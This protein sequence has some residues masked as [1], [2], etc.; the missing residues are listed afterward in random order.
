MKLSKNY[1]NIMKKIY[2]REFH[3][4]RTI[5]KYTFS[6][7]RKY[8][9][10]NKLKI[11]KKI[12]DL[13]VTNFR[14]S[15]DLNILEK[16]AFDDK[17]RFKS[18][19]RKSFLAKKENLKKS[20]ILNYYDGKITGNLN[21]DGVQ[22]NVTPKFKKGEEVKRTGTFDDK[23]NN[24]LIDYNLIKSNLNNT[25]LKLRHS[26]S[27]NVFV[28]KNN[29]KQMF[30]SYLK[31]KK[32][33][34][35]NDK[36]NKEDKS[37]I[38]KGKM[39]RLKLFLLESKK[40]FTN[41]KS[42][43]SL[44]SIRSNSNKNI[45]FY[46]SKKV[47]KKPCLRMKTPDDINYKRSIIKNKKIIKTSNKSVGFDF[48]SDKETNFNLNNNDKNDYNKINIS[49]KLAKEL[50]DICENE[51]NFS[52]CSTE[53]E[54]NSKFKELSIENN[55]NFEIMPSYPNLNK[56]TKGKYIN[57]FHLQKKLKFIL[58]N[59]YLYK[60]NNKKFNTNDSLLLKAILFP[61]DSKN[62]NNLDINEKAKNT[63]HKNHHKQNYSSS[64]IK[65]KEKYNNTFYGTNKL[66]KINKTSKIID[67]HYL[68][69]GFLIDSY[70]LLPFYWLFGLLFCLFYL[71]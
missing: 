67:Q 48:G 55:L 21:L 29:F 25:K 7:L 64:K 20:K 6:V 49:Q 45:K 68:I 46:L 14:S 28:N 47:N 59:Y 16:S 5:K 31:R 32:Y 10:I 60:H 18:N 22:I 11:N 53:E 30:K 3:N 66:F 33:Y 62:E 44:N 41:N 36:E 61:L 38:N 65:S 58:Q 17:S 2:R 35:K 63:K 39:K 37:V 23:K 56:L 50:K 34:L 54:R 52:F 27:P 12:N 43:K 13:K 24:N 71:F 51:S 57:D 8:I 1:P 69:F 4:L 26:L 15:F 19:I 9:E 42:S 70:F 40:Y